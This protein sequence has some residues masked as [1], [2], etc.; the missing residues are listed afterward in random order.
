LLLIYLRQKTSA[1]IYLKLIVLAALTTCQHQP[2][3]LN[4]IWHGGHIIRRNFSFNVAEFL[5][6]DSLMSKEQGFW[7]RSHEACSPIL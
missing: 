6:T 4:E 3:D 1:L 2:I 5:E 7:N